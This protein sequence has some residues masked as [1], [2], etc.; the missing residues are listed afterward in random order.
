M[1]LFKNS[2]S[3]KI[4]WGVGI[5]CV[6]IFLLL[7][8]WNYYSQWKGEKQVEKLANALKQMEQ[9]IYDKKAADTI[10]GKTPQETLDMYI[11]A[12][13]AEDYELASKYLIIEKQQ[14]EL[15]ILQT[16]KKENIENIINNKL[17]KTNS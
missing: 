5:F 8:G 13:E 3:N 10:G 12:I 9:E 17:L 7:A 4:F 1:A 6:V 2:K 14:E 11:K 15:K 16:S